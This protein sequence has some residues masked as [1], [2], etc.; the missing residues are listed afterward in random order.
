MLLLSLLSGIHIPANSTLPM[1]GYYNFGNPYNINIDTFNH[2]ILHV[3]LVV[4]LFLLFYFGRGYT[5]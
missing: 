2:Y 5:N 4:P 1:I 3:L